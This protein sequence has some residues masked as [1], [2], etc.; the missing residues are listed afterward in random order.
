MAGFGVVFWNTYD[1]KLPYYDN[2]KSML[3][4]NFS[5]GTL[6]GKQAY[7]NLYSCSVDLK[8]FITYV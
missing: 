5:A 1:A 6:Y 7:K 3:S 2:K 8:F 4:T